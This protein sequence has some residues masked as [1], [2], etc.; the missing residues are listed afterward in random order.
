MGMFGDAD[1]LP[2]AS[3]ER[4][5]NNWVEAVRQLSQEREKAAKGKG[6]GKPQLSQE[7]ETAAAPLKAVVLEIGAGD[8]VPTVRREAEHATRMWRMGGTETTLVRVNPDIP[9][10]DH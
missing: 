10:G 4:Q 8:R 5:F 9:Y 7:R 2:M 6:K 3:Q 1:W